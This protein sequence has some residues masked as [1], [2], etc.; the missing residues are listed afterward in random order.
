MPTT[1]PIPAPMMAP[2]PIHGTLYPGRRKVSVHWL[3]HSFAPYLELRSPLSIARSCSRIHCATTTAR[4]TSNR[5]V[6]PSPP[7]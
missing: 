7:A 3:I 2:T 1:T 5:C 6:R 4:A